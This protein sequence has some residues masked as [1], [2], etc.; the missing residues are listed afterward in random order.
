MIIKWSILRL[1]E[2]VRMKIIR[3][4]IEK[5]LKSTKYGKEMEEKVKD[6]EEN[7]DNLLKSNFN[8][9]HERKSLKEEIQRLSE[10]CG[11]SFTKKDFENELAI[12]I[13][14]GKIYTDITI[15][16]INNSVKELY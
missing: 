9:S 5:V 16:E 13:K 8:L 3:V 6:L 12:L 2:R 10:E 15:D 14:K 7:Q 11:I 4:L 1:K